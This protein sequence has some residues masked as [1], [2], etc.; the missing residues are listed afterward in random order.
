[1]AGGYMVPMEGDL[2]DT[3]C[4]SRLR[5]RFPDKRTFATSPRVG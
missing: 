2:L 1:M 4:P 3:L 5:E